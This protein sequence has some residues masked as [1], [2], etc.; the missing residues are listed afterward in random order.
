MLVVASVLACITLLALVFALWLSFD[1]EEGA[2]GQVP[3][4]A[5]AVAV[6]LSAIFTVSLVDR[7]SPQWS[8]PWWGYLAG[9]LVA[10]VLTGWLISTAGIPGQRAHR[11]RDGGS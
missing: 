3:V 9:F 4:L 10:V 8:A 7:A 2:I 6:P 1:T 11:R 5:Y